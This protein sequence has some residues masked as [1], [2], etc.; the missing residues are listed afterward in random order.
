MCSSEKECSECLVPFYKLDKECIDECPVGMYSDETSRE[1]YMCDK[2]CIS[3]YGSTNREC[4]A[5]NTLAGYSKSTTGYCRLMECAEGTYL[6]MTESFQCLPCHDSCSKCKGEGK[7]N[8]TSCSIGLVEA[9]LDDLIV[10]SV[11]D[12]G[13]KLDEKGT[14]VGTLSFS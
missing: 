4:S 12:V 9:V 2:S 8:C 14:C 1:C 7:N 10:C 5:C 3:C 13:F 11:C 6:S